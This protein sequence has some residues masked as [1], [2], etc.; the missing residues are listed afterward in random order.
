MDL[1][2]KFTVVFFFILL[3]VLIFIYFKKEKKKGKV[4]SKKFL[5][6]QRKMDD[7]NDKF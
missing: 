3:I 5:D 4:P 1:I 2:D 7:R 6:E